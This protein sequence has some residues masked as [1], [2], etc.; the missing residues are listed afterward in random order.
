MMEEVRIK[1]Q[2]GRILIH[3]GHCPNGCSLINPDKPMFGKPAI[4]A[5]VRL[6]GASGMIHLN[7]YYGIFEYESDLELGPGDTVDLYCPHCNASLSVEELCGMCNAPMFAIHLPDGGEVRACPKMD[8]NNHSL[9]IVDLDAQI[10][11]FYNE[12]RRPKM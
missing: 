4:S 8:C 11:E 10:A 5:L 9:T 1:I 2:P 6:R 7:P 3:E 12:E